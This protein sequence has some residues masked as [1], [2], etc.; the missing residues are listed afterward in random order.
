MSHLR[1]Y[2]LLVTWQLEAVVIVMTVLMPIQFLLSGL[3]AVG[4]GYLAP[5]ID[6]ATA[7]YLS[8][9]APTVSVL[10]VGMV[11]LPQQ[12]SQDKTTG[13]HDFYRTLPVSPVVRLAAFLTPHLISSLPGALLS[14]LVASWYFDFSLQLGPE[15]IVALM[16]V[17]LCG[18]AI[19]NA[20]AIVSPH[21]I[22]TTVM[23]NI[24]LFFVMLFSPINY[25][26]ERLPGW[27]ESVHRVLPVESMAELVRASLTDA[28]ATGG[29]WLKVIAWSVGAFAVSAA[30]SARR[31]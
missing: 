19:G 8:T 26:V 9:G 2:R 28:T 20:V 16:C 10:L 3:L 18:A 30:F 6:P 14:L 1:A 27:L 4:L 17:A 29:E 22:V 15:L 12:Q 31:G 11:V 7:I 25:P 13:G 21:P 5:E 23:T 24:L